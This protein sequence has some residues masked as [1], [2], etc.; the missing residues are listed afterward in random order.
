MDSI[1]SLNMVLIVHSFLRWVLLRTSMGSHV[2]LRATGTKCASRVLAQ[3]LKI[4]NSPTQMRILRPQMR[5]AES[6]KYPS[7][8]KYDFVTM[9][10][11]GVEC[12]EV[13][14]RYDGYF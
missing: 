2:F 8:T 4:Q 5:A 11:G 6:P 10:G 14:D 9:C 3:N 13:F 12:V 7:G 1:I